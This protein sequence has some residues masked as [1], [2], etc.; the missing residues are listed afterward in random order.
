[1]FL[2]DNVDETHNTYNI[3]CTYSSV[4]GCPCFLASVRV[5]TIKAVFSAGFTLII[6]TEKHRKGVFLKKIVQITRNMQK[7]SGAP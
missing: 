4:H 1:M 7:F 6:C 2:F 5:H 3:D